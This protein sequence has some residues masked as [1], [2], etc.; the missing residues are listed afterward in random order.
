MV[1]ARPMTGGYVFKGS[2]RITYAMGRKEYSAA[3]RAN[4]LRPRHFVQT[5]EPVT[6]IEISPVEQ[7]DRAIAIIASDIG[8][9]RDQ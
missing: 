9:D 1:A 4:R 5:L 2:F 3:G 7:H 8:H 6:V